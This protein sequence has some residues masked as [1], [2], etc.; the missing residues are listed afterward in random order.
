VTCPTGGPGEAARRES[1]AG[2][3]LLHGSLG[4]Y[5]YQERWA[6]LLTSHGYVTLLVDSFGPRNLTDSTGIVSDRIWD[7]YG[8]LQHLRTLPFVR[9]HRVAVM[10]WSQGGLV[11]VPPAARI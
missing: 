10:G 1:I 6:Q 9:R 5:P 2:Q 11:A 7:A 4:I 8:A 3:L